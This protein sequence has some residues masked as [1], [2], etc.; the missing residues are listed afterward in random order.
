VFL[1]SLPALGFTMLAGPIS[2]TYGRKPLIIL[3]I[4][5]FIILNFVFLINEIWFTELKVG[6]LVKKTKYK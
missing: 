1:Q 4:F 3:P 5:G 6:S 2:D